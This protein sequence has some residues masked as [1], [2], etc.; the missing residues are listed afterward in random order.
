VTRDEIEAARQNAHE[1]QNMDPHQFRNTKQAELCKAVAKDLLA[2]CIEARPRDPGKCPGC[3]SG[4]LGGKMPA[5]WVPLNE[6]G[7]PIGEWADW[8]GETEMEMGPERCC[9]ECGHEW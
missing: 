6:A 8:E 2:L 4:D 3:G 7:E 1:L 9:F 5:F